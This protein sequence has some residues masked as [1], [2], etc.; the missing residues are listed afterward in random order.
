MFNDALPEFDY[1]FEEQLRQMLRQE[2]V[3]ANEKK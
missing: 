2:C 1:I 3:K